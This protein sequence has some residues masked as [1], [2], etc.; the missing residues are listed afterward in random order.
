M[1]LHHENLDYNK[2]CKYPFG[3]YVQA[4]QEPTPKNS[5][6][7]R[8]IDCIYLRYVDNLQGGH[9][10]LDLAT[11]HVITQRCITPVPLTRNIIDIVH[12]MADKDGMTKELKITTKRNIILYDSSWIPG[13]DF[14]EENNEIEDDFDYTEDDEMN[15]NEIA[16]IHGR[17]NQIDNIQENESDDDNDD[18]ASNNQNQEEENN[19]SNS[20]NVQETLINQPTQQDMSRDMNITTTRS[21][22]QSKPPTKMNLHQC[23]LLTQAQEEIE[24]QYENAQIGAKNMTEINNQFY[25]FMSTYNLKQG[26]KRFGKEGYEAAM[27]ELRQLNER[28]VFKPI[29]IQT[30]THQEKRRTMDNLIFLVNKR[31]GRIKARTC[32]NGSTQRRSI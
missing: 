23:H 12:K 10:L 4:H 9:H 2:Y 30:M 27:Q 6:Y 19:D 24:Y 8:T 5:Q 17:E 14:E 18:D 21:G 20:D 15:P 11:G 3:S 13:V 32:A 7:A 28:E 1:I 22:R 31:D 29:S 16:E 26:I 25:Q